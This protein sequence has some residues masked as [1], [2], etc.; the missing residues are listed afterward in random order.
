[1]AM[2]C[3]KDTVAAEVAKLHRRGEA[4]SD[5]LRIECRWCASGYAVL[6]NGIWEF[7]DWVTDELKPDAMA[8]R[9][10]LLADVRGKKLRK[11]MEE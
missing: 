7:S 11:A 10:A 4:P 1:M 9:T 8:Q 3:C 2:R 6:R 5:G